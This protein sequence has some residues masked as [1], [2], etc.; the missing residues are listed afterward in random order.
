MTAMN[1]S[2][3]IP[4]VLRQFAILIS[5]R[6][7][8]PPLHLELPAFGCLGHE[9]VLDLRDCCAVHPRQ[10]MSLPTTT[11]ICLDVL[12]VGASAA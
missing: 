5:A 4:I 6:A 3:L 9:K 10:L 11:R 7:A 1:V 2:G 12:E 8:G